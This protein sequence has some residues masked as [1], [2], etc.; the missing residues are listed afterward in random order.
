VPELDCLVDAALEVEGVLGTR[1]TG[2]GFGGCTVILLRSTAREALCA[3][4]EMR[5]RARF[6][7]APELGFYSGDPGPREISSATHR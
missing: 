7:R 1:L 4:V 2:A 6:G 5:F 3:N